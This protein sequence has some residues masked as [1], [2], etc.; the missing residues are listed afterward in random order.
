M[1]VYF[2]G[3][4]L[5]LYNLSPLEL[6]PGLLYFSQTATVQNKQVIV[7]SCTYRYTESRDAKDGDY[8]FRYE[9]LLNPPRREI[10][11]S[12]LHI[13]ACWGNGCPIEDIHFPTSRISIEQVIAH[14][15]IEHNVKPIKGDWFEILADSHND[16][17]RNLREKPMF[18]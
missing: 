16:F 10:P 17:V 9:Y 5:G 11:H 3:R 4:F 13:K 7:T 1:P 2:I 12:H 14:L 6:R 18:Y 8:L 15:I